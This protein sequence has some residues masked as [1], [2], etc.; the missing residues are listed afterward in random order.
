MQR[1]ERDEL[2]HRRDQLVVDERRRREPI[3]A[4]HDPM[5]D[6]NDVHVGKRGPLRLERPYGG[7]ERGFVVGDRLIVVPLTLRP[8]MDVM[9]AVL[10]DLLHEAGRGGLTRGRVDEAV[11]ER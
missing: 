11:L 6:R 2:R 10:A 8:V 3:A 7:L 1:S 4:M 9:A 5:P